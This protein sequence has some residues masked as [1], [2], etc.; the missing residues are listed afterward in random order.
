[1]YAWDSPNVPIELGASIFVSVNKILVD[2]VQTFNLSINDKLSSRLTSNPELGIWNG[3]EFVLQTSANNGWWDIAKLLWRYGLAPIK[4]NRLMKST[5]GSFLKLYEEPQF[6][7]ASLTD[8]V[9][10]VGL[11]PVTASTGEQYLQ[12]N[13][14]GAKF[15]NE[16]IQARCVHL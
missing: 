16:V 6:P 4:T 3:E 12:K 10:D 1:V 11:T 2:A 14:I 15:A 8:V 7:F 5:V 9:Y 13:G